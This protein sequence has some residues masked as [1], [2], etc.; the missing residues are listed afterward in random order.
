MKCAGKV[1]PKEISGGIAVQYSAVTATLRN[2]ILH[3]RWWYQ[4]PAQVGPIL[5][6]KHSGLNLDFF[7]NLEQQALF[8]LH[9][10]L[11]ELKMDLLMH[12]SWRMDVG[13]SLIFAAESWLYHSISDQS[14]ALV[15]EILGKDLEKI[16]HWGNSYCL[17]N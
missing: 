11:E 12:F 3:C 15:P 4:K 17:V 2:L 14:T 13:L 6:F 9:F 7:L 8:I 16:S 1:F 5:F 10:L